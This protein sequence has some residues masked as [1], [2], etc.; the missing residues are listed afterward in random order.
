MKSLTLFESK[1]ITN[2]DYNLCFIYCCKYISLNIKKILE[3][4]QDLKMI[5]TRFELVTNIG[6][7][8]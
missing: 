8:I 6:I 1:N 5:A 7:L 3:M 4:V 2:D